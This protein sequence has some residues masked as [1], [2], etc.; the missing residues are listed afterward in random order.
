MR[1][2]VAVTIKH[3]TQLSSPLP[4]T[5]PS[6]NPSHSSSPLWI[7]FVWWMKTPVVLGRVGVPKIKSIADDGSH[8]NKTALCLMCIIC[9]WTGYFG[10]QNYKCCLS[11]IICRHFGNNVKLPS[12]IKLL[13]NKTFPKQIS[14][15]IA[16]QNPAKLVETFKQL[17]L[18]FFQLFWFKL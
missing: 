14:D 3:R 1:P 4:T 8:C 5:L 13:G 10:V 9:W 16:N 11:T 17:R 15:A 6:L 2:H 12:D 7:W 18:R